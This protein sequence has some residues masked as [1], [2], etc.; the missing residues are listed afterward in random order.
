MP[1]VLDMVNTNN[2][3]VTGGSGFIGLH[4]VKQLLESGYS[5]N[6]TTRSL[7]SDTALPLKEMAEQY[8]GKLHIFEATLLEE[9]SFAESMRGVD[10][11]FH[12]ATPVMPHS[13]NVYESQIRP[14]IEGTRNVLETCLLSPSV[15]TVVLTSSAFTV[16]SPTPTN[17]HNYTE[18][19]FTN[20]DDSPDMAYV[21]AKVEAEKYALDFAQ[22][23]RDKIRLVCLNP[24]FVFGPEIQVKGTHGTLSQPRSNVGRDMAISFLNGTRD[25]IPSGTATFDNY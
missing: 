9:G 21:I 12:L 25:T 10:A 1:L 2:V 3:L 8:P 11:V 4:V 24:V 23:H 17:N 19:D 22:K 16:V 18:D 13:D 7:A 6:T 14:A 15:K 20:P 5:V